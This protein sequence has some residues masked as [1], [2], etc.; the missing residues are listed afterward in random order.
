MQVSYS[1]NL[2][3]RSALAV[4]QGQVSRDLGK[5]NVPMLGSSASSVI[6]P[7]NCYFQE[8]IFAKGSWFVFRSSCLCGEQLCAQQIMPWGAP[9]PWHCS[10]MGRK[11]TPGSETPALCVW[12]VPPTTVGQEGLAVQLQADPEGCARL[13][14]P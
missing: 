6:S 3:G 10:A 12:G 13:L 9:E 5:R 1:N 2:W 14:L 8:N 7:Q 4:K 11:G